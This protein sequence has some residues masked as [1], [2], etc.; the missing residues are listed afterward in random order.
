MELQKIEWD[1]SKLRGRI[2]EK[3]GT[4]ENFATH[5]PF[6]RTSLSQ[7]LTNKQ[8]F[9]TKEI[10]TAVK[11]LDLEEGDIPEYFFKQKV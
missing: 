5:M 6:G 9:D 8:A 1:F 11:L 10:L 7:R 2:K 3:Y 4:E